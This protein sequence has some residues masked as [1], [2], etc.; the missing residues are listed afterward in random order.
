MGRVS[1]AK[2]SRTRGRL[3][4][5]AVV[6]TVG[7]GLVD[8]TAAHAQQATK[9]VDAADDGEMEK[10]VRASADP[11]RFLPG[12]VAAQAGGALVA[13]SGWGGYDG[14]T[15]APPLGSFA[16]ARLARWLVLGV[17]VVY[18]QGNDL[19]PAA[20]RPSVVARAQ[21]PR[22]AAPR[23][24][25]QR[26]LRVPGRSI[27]RRGR[28]LSGRVV[29]RTGAA[30]PECCSATSPSGATGK[31]TITRASCGWSVW[32]GWGDAS[33]SASTASSGAPSTRPIRVT[34]STAPHRS[35]TRWA[36]RPLATS[37]RSALF[38]ETG[39]TGVQLMRFQNGLLAIGGL[40]AVLIHL[41]T[42]RAR[43][44]V[45]LRLIGRCPQAAA[46][47]CMVCP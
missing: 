20:A 9:D 7:A 37:A 11:T 44:P 42:G 18:A 12:V 35:S 29:L 40:G 27:R 32:R 3:R 14:A 15:H 17:G 28:V 8:A 34:P 6:A 45:H 1:F 10:T 23:N 33:I 16:E 39:V 47:R 36:P 38:V 5:A 30:R 25:R 24:R 26:R 22:P 46:V 31:A 19:Q 41:R 2:R 4:C 21:I 43:A 13:G